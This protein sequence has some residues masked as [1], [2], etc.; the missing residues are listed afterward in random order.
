MSGLHIIILLSSLHIAFG[1]KKVKVDEKIRVIEY[2]VLSEHENSG[3]YRK[4][5]ELSRFI[6]EAALDN[7]IAT[8][9]LDYNQGTETLIPVET[10]KLRLRKV[11]EPGLEEIYSPEEVSLIGIDVTEG[12][13][14]HQVFRQYNFLNLHV[15]YYHSAT[16]ANNYVASFRFDDVLALL[17]DMQVLW[18]SES[19]A[20]SHA[21]FTNHGGHPL[22][23]TGWARKLLEDV[24]LGHLNAVFN[25]G[26]NI[27][28]YR[29]KDGYAVDIRLNESYDGGYLVLD[30]IELYKSVDDSMPHSDRFICA[31]PFDDY[32]NYLKDP[33]STEISLMSE[34]LMKR[35][36]T[37]PSEVWRNR[38]ENFYDSYF[39][40][41]EVISK[42]GISTKNDCPDIYSAGSQLQP[43]MTDRE[44]IS[45]SRFSIRQTSFVDGRS[46][47]DGHL[48]EMI[49]SILDAALNGSLVIYQND[50]LQNTLSPD[51]F[52][53]C[54]GLSAHEAML[55]IPEIEFIYL[56]SFD[57]H[58]EKISYT[59]VGL[60]ILDANSNPGYFSFQHLP[61]V[62][63]SESVKLFLTRDF[64]GFVKQTGH[65]L[66]K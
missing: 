49:P 33:A 21:L 7:K 56:L 62:L 39:I 48:K 58:G 25:E 63:S 61:Q 60:G 2:H 22:N 5:Q 54:F 12:R 9:R 6:L 34:A 65:I 31:I 40:D 27:S 47:E 36:L 16:T 30:S 15:P 35:I 8:Y 4:N 24:K 26:I 14:D 29:A 13:K 23:E 66:M 3:F 38:F 42:N 55:M 45:N 59:P 57:I 19:Y 41:R 1:Q 20:L 50:S 44:E 18:Y 17:D 37:S 52:K 51:E 28:G 53:A 46:I 11:N 10:L 32:R 64:K 43:Q